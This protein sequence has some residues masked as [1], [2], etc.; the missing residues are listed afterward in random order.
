MRFVAIISYFALMCSSCSGTD[1]VVIDEAFAACKALGH[2]VSSEFSDGGIMI[3]AIADSSKKNGS[4]LKNQRL[5]TFPKGAEGKVFSAC[6][7]D[8]GRREIVGFSIKQESVFA[9]TPK[10]LRSF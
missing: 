7:V 9:D 6:E 4:E 3:V 2:S 10:R 5:L 8:V 1:E